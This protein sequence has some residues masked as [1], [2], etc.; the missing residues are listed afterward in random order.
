MSLASVYKKAESLE[1][2]SDQKIETRFCLQNV[3][4]SHDLHEMHRWVSQVA[5][6]TD[7]S[8]CINVTKL[9]SFTP[10]LQHSV[11]L[12]CF[13]KRFCG[14]DLFDIFCILR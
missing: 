11:P 5:Q 4:S 7:N 3:L 9:N 2:Q 10:S 13:P 12:I 6:T 14:V 1:R 8:C